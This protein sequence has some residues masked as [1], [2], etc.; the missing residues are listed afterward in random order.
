M[1]GLGPDAAAFL[2][3][4]V[5]FDPASVVRLQ[6]TDRA[7][8]LWSRLPFGVLVS[9]SVPGVVPGD[10]PGDVTVRADALLRSLETGGPLPPSR[11]A[12]WRWPL[13]PATV[14]TVERLPAAEVTRVSAAAADTIRTASAE[15]VGGRAVG[16]RAIRDA[17]LDHVPI[18]VETDDG[19][20]FHVPQRLVQA[21]TRMGFVPSAA[22][23]GSA[24]GSA[25]DMTVE[26]RVG[27]P[28]VGL[29]APFGSAWYRPP[30]LL[31]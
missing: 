19:E 27:G 31:R 29:A 26:V 13:P 25:E 22:A 9:R 3:R 8:I 24:G 20:R 16:S 2:A 30:L 12:D 7:V 5:R 1:A 14:R 15:G 18:V 6:N 11:D 4:V 21:I 28:W 10:V 23:V 17:L